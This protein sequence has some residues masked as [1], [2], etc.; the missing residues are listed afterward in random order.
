MLPFVAG[1]AAI[2]A[3]GAVIVR[4]LPGFDHPHRI[5]AALA[6]DL[7]FTV[8]FLAWLFPVRAG[9]WP[10]VSLIPVFLLSV[11]AAARLL[12]ADEQTLV[13][14]LRT[15]G[16]PAELGLLGWIALR[17][18][19]SVRSRAP[20]DPDLDLLARIRRASRGILWN[21]A[22]A[23][24]LAFELAVLAYAFGPRRAPYAPAGA[25]A[26]GYDQ[27]TP[28]G[29]VVAALGLVVLAETVPFHFLIARW[30]PRAAWLVTAFGLYTLIYLIADWRA[31]RARPILL[32]AETL[33]I[34]TGI[35]WTVRVP[36]TS[37]SRIERRAP[38]GD[39]KPL[40]AALLGGANLWLHLADPVEAIGAYG[41]KRRVTT[42]ALAV[43]EP[44]RLLA[45]L[46]L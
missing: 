7:T 34:R 31:T 46:A 10:A 39:E 41:R 2:Y 40:R 28:Y 30:S 45:D 25:A 8:T 33:L 4:A 9:R 26:F 27:R 44:D 32:D 43:D 29:P 14:T 18:A 23:E 22:V 5:A 20:V 17:A 42:I 6:F 19:R 35:R 21:P 15:L 24:A 1:A 11:A 3:L 13:T 37:I 16:A 12:P 36:R 38:R